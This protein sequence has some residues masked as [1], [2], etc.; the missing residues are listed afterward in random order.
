MDNKEK[1][2]SFPISDGINILAQVG[3]NIGTCVELPSQMKL[4]FSTV[5]AVMENCE[6]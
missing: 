6:G 4:S 3:V 1:R 5:N 2:E